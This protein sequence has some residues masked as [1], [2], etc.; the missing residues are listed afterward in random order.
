M[1]TWCSF[2]LTSA[3][4][5]WCRFTPPTGTPRWFKQASKPNLPQLHN[6][7]SP[8]TYQTANTCCIIWIYKEWPTSSGST[9]YS[10]V[11]LCSEPLAN[12]QPCVRIGHF[13]HRLPLL[14]D[15]EDVLPYIPRAVWAQWR[16]LAMVNDNSSLADHHLRHTMTFHPLKDVEVHSLQELVPHTDTLTLYTCSVQNLPGLS[17]SLWEFIWGI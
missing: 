6:F 3:V 15:S 10:N 4:P 9:R 5:T 13:P 2:T 8:S 16:Y 7:S 17:I 11:H 14:Q 1:L 12:V